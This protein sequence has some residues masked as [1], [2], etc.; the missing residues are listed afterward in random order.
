MKVG[1]IAPIK[2][3]EEYCRSDVQYCLPCLIVNEPKYRHFYAKRASMGNTIILDCRQIGWKREPEKLSIVEETLHHLT[4]TI[5]ISPSC[6]FNS[7][8][9][10][11]TQEEFIYS[12]PQLKNKLIRC[13]EGTSK[14]EIDKI[15]DKERIA[16]PS[17][18]YRYLSNLELNSHTIYIDNHLTLDELQGK[19]GILVTSLPL[20][21]GLQGRLLSDYKPAPPSLTFY[22]D[23]DYYP[24]ITKRNV[25]EALEYY[26][27]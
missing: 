22:E 27:D 21:L 14:E 7:K 2:F 13:I 25:A 11:E 5:V 16:A 3:L 9:T 15:K 10:R 17:H 20:R 1:I 4:P 24:K 12:F 23:E 6:M 18:M 19:E 26:E 8:R